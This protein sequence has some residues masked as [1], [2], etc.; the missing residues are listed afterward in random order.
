MKMLVPSSNYSVRLSK[1]LWTPLWNIGPATFDL[2][3]FS[4]A[5]DL[6]NLVD[7]T[8]PKVLMLVWSVCGCGLLMKCRCACSWNYDPV[9]FDLGAVILNLGNLWMTMCLKY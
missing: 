2:G 5:L 6:R 4:H 1:L 3:V 9:T 7:A 8:V